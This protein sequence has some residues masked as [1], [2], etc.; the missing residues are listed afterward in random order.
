MWLLLQI[1]ADG[2]KKLGKLDNFW[3]LWEPYSKF[4]IKLVRQ[5]QKKFLN[6]P[7]LTE[8]KS[9]SATSDSLL[10]VLV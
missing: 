1:S 8:S 3:Q 6:D 10:S 4:L 7:S 5:Q 2:E 9:I